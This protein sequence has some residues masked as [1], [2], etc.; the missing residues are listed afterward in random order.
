MRQ[1][2]YKIA[3]DQKQGGGVALAKVVL[4]LLSLVY[5]FFVKL[6]TLF[7]NIGLFKKYR[8]PC[9][10]ISVGNLTVGGVGKTPIVEFIAQFLQSKNVQTAILTRGY[11][12]NQT[13]DGGQKSDEVAMLE[14]ELSG[15]SVLV[16]P[17][18][19]QNAQRHLE[20]HATGVFLLDDGFQ[21][22]KLSRDLDIV[23]I[24]TTNPWGNGCL[25]P[26]GVLRESKSALKRADLFIVTKADLG[27]EHLPKIK[28]ELKLM[29]PETMIVETNHQP[30]CLVNAQSGEKVNLE[31]ICGKKICAV[32]SIG[33]PNSFTLTLQKLGA[34]IEKHFAFMDHHNYKKE[35]VE[36][37]GK[38]CLNLGVT[39][40]ITTEKDIV[41][42]K[43]FLDVIPDQIHVY[44]LKIKIIVTSGEEQLL[45]RVDN[46]L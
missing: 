30:V 9:R 40:I 12:G 11:M 39:A 15:I 46:I 45:E 17:N 23:A 22:L 28:E 26:R 16:G 37:I 8:L 44:S 21:H 6:R 27:N 38:A 2:L 10:V 41:K 34:V 19:V 35:D 32:S 13:I 7:Y 36:R 1:F 33:S 42:L 4:W 5:H 14:K 24:D 18:R 43:D 3:T 29:C 31:L 20:H 25:L